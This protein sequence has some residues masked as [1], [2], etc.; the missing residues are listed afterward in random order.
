[1]NAFCVVI[2]E[3]AAAL[4]TLPPTTKAAAVQRRLVSRTSFAT[5]RSSRMVST[6][7]LPAAA[8]AA[9]A[10]DRIGK[11]DAT[12]TTLLV[13]DIQERFI[14]VIYHAPTVVQT[15]RYMTNVAKTLSMPIVVTQQYTKAFGPTVSSCFAPP[16]LSAITVEDKAVPKE[17]GA[18]DPLEGIPIFEKKL[19]SMITPEVQDHLNA[20]S[21]QPSDAF[22]VV[23]IEAHVCVQQ[24][25]LDL[26]E[27]G[28]AVHLIVDGVSSQQRLDREIALQR[29][30]AAGV[31]MTTAQSAVFMLMKSA[32]H[33][34]FKTISKLTV[35]HMKLINEF[36]TAK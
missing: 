26:L 27:Q 19:F 2:P 25:C 34:H 20:Q 23:G 17:A 33:E 7:S 22:I 4:G 30:A 35:E 14:P 15:C 6:T 9:A 32:E 1:V 31:F 3:A 8:S 28:K 29:L 13:C 11:L 21:P 24:T 5:N 36:D 18:V 10:T 16:P 12:K